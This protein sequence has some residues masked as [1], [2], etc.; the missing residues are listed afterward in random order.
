M[1]AGER[2]LLAFVSSVQRPELDWARR[3]TVEALTE[4]PATMPWAFE[5]TPVSSQ[6]ADKTY[7]AKVREADIFIWLIGSETVVN[8][9]SRPL[10]QFGTRLTVCLRTANSSETS[11]AY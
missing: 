11:P 8:T 5:F 10:T 9:N 6:A 2:P 4:N 7:L 1:V 3:T